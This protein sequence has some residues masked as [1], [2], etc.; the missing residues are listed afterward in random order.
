MSRSPA[1]RPAVPGVHRRRITGGIAA[2]LV[3]ALAVSGP[4]PTLASRAKL[5]KAAGGIG[6]NFT[7]K[8]R[9]VIRLA[10]QAFDPLKSQPKIPAALRATV[11]ANTYG[12]YLV[13]LRYPI[14][15][16][17]RDAVLKAARRNEGYFP[18]ATY[19][20][21]LTPESAAKV[22]AIKGVRWVGLFHP[23]YKLRPKMA[24]TPGV[25]DVARRRELHAYLF[26][27]SNL[28]TV[29]SQMRGIP[30]VT[31]HTKRSTS[32]VV[33]FSASRTELPAV[34]RIRAIQWVSEKPTYRLHNYNARWASDTGER[35]SFY[36]TLDGRLTGAG[37]TSANADTGANYITDSNGKA[38]RAFADFYA[39]GRTKLADYV[40]T[41]GGNTQDEMFVR[42]DNN[43]NHRKVAAY[44]D[45]GGDGYEPSEASN[46]GTHTGGSIAAD[47]ADPN[48]NF[49]TYNDPAF[50]AD[51]L[52]P[53]AHFIFQDVAT[54]PDGGL[55]GLPAA[56]IILG[57]P[58]DLYDLYEQV[59]DGN[60]T[61]GDTVT[62]QYSSELHANKIYSYD[63]ELD[64]RTHNYS[65]GSIQPV[66][67]LGSGTSADR[68]VYD[69]ED[70][71][72]VS[73]ASNDG[74][75]I[76]TMPGGPQT[77][78]NALTSCAS[79]GGRQPMITLDSAAIF[80]SHGLTLDGRLKPDVCTPGQ[81]VVSPK[82]ATND[83]DQYLQGTS[84]SSPVLT[85]LA[86]LV[87]QYFADGYGPRPLT[88]GAVG[89]AAGEKRSAHRFNPSSALVRAA[90]INSA[91]R[92]RGWY[93]GDEGTER[94]LDGQWPSAG[95]GWG[96]VELANALYFQG[97]ARRQFVADIRNTSANALEFSAQDYEI[98]VKAGE[99]LDIV[100]TWTDVPSVLVAGTSPL[101]NN[102]DLS[103]TGPDGTTYVGNNF[104]TQSAL[105]F[106][107]PPGTPS[108]D[109]GETRPGSALADIKNNTERIR[110]QAPQTGTYTVHIDGGASVSNLIGT[111]GGKQGYAL[112]ATGLLG[113]NASASRVSS[114][115]APAITDVSVTT[116]ASDLA[117]ATW[118][119]SVP[120]TGAVLVTDASGNTTRFDDV[121][122]PST[123]HGLETP[124]NENKGDY[125]DKKVVSKT[126]EVRLTGLAAGAK[127]VVK[128]ESSNVA[129]SQTTTSG[130]IGFTLTATSIQGTTTSGPIEFTSTA[131]MF[132]P[133]AT[134][135]AQL[136]DLDATTGATPTLPNQQQWGTSTQLY[137][138]LLPSNAS[139]PPIVPGLVEDLTGL[140]LPL[141]P[142]RKLLPSFM[143]R[144][145]ASVD[146]SRI[147]GAALELTG[148][149]DITNHYTQDVRF[150]ALLLNSSVEDTW[151]PNTGY[152]TVADAPVDAAVPPDTGVRR[153]AG[154]KYV[155]SFTC[156]DLEA[157]KQNLAGDRS[158]GEE[159]AA[160]RIESS[161][162]NDPDVAESV[163]SFE[164]GYG[165]R[166]RG[167]EFRPRLLL[168]IDGEDAQPCENV[169]APTIEEVQV[170]PADV[171]KPTSVTVSWRTD[172][173]A[174]SIVLFRKRGTSAW[175]QTGT[176]FRSTL[177]LVH[178]KGLEPYGK[179]EFAV[180]SRTC[181]GLE[182][183]DDNANR[184]YA[185]FAESFY[186]PVLDRIHAI[187]NL[188]GTARIGW[189]TD[190]D[191]D[192][193][194]QYGTSPNA[195]GTTAVEKDEEGATPPPDK[196]H[197]VDLAG[198]K[199]CTAYYFR[200][201]STN[202]AGARRT[203]PILA[204]T[205]PSNVTSELA[206]IE[207]F[208]SGPGAFTIDTPN[209]GAVATKWA[210]SNGA[211]RTT[212]GGAVP[213]Y[214]S[215]ADARLVSPSYAT[216]GGGIELTFTETFHSETDFDYGIVE[217]SIN[218]GKSWI[219][220]RAIT[221]LAATTPR[222]VTV[223]IP[224]VP[225]G[226]M[227]IRWRMKSDTNLEYQP[228]WSV[229]NVLV[230]EHV[231]CAD[232]PTL[233]PKA[234]LTPKSTVTFGK[235]IAPLVGPVPARSALGTL[236]A[237]AAPSAVTVS[238][239]SKAAGSA[240]CVNVA[241]AKTTRR[242]LPRPAPGTVLP[243]TGVSWAWMPAV[244]LMLG[245]LWLR[246][247][248][249][250]TR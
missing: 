113:P 237:D 142:R 30:G 246:R 75:G 52:A 181:N 248:L 182:T 207:T 54:G 132:Q 44:Y 198:L 220:V 238:A 131:A 176:P 70:F 146:P 89:Y 139:D 86:T 64:A 55:G 239:A 103:V 183:T 40:Q 32:T 230:K 17:A 27:G 174:S 189:V 160:F 39:N 201:V 121:Y 24:G 234:P 190:V 22:R 192:A 200:A 102:L 194:V 47:Y 120:T 196:T 20:L 45:L 212:I 122:N 151:G 5:V 195:L 231:P 177:H 225:Q 188:D 222:D 232:I 226:A 202:G 63:P 59:Y 171:E 144:L 57:V 249:L 53:G 241:G 211:M 128:V 197:E 145:P 94:S 6:E 12:W 203:G 1:P 29:L 87:R 60:P 216:K 135:I 191:S 35:D 74:P 221:G 101:V 224:D 25:L 33:V 109:V 49:G 104:T 43:T 50:G 152:S 184:G 138:G 67:D 150:N 210:N 178:V 215:S 56:G 10:Y 13:Q 155:F 76:F 114:A 173:P 199:P 3:T 28:P 186:P 205:T 62:N 91:E 98:P 11:K 236:D 58:D 137:A 175:T 51:G 26:R 213:A 217:Y 61:V 73:S 158:G 37:Q 118:K 18:E 130:T 147:T 105:P 80:S 179:Y 228:G 14:R 21:E 34:A 77:A 180:R 129:P 99:P 229:D 126:H 218:D 16:P 206:P 235:T 154:T 187:P 223:L 41:V 127:Y 2:V 108:E 161:I 124:Q 7:M 141:P 48:G 116:I 166:S 204:F 23:A 219:P 164:P 36:A 134:D 243:G 136:T 92:M 172:V 106:N 159:R 8:G 209:D 95:Q 115:D 143:F 240:I 84:M 185:L 79:A 78:K 157:L 193:V 111:P 82:G 214:G 247:R 83:A 107:T 31:V 208:D 233:T 4:V 65:I 110:I 42:T 119:T 156:G 46:H 169:P 97:G 117:L 19:L 90:I 72:I 149:H 168:Q 96:R 165:R 133:K 38:Q 71:V 68:F 66:L 100:L 69:H 88:A 9:G 112:V 15:K 93:T 85:G 123:F 163:F 81:I 140:Q 242:I 167:P 162:L 245:A 125:A 153:G 250:T 170:Q 148:G 227:K 244:A